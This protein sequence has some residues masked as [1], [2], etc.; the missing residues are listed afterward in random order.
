[1]YH[2]DIPEEEIAKRFGI[3]GSYMSGV[4]THDP[5]YNRGWYSIA[6]RAAIGQFAIQMPE[7][8]RDLEKI[9]EIRAKY[10]KNGVMNMAKVKEEAAPIINQYAGYKNYESILHNPNLA[11]MRGYDMLNSLEGREDVFMLLSNAANFNEV[12]DEHAGWLAQ[13]E[14]AIRN[15]PILARDISGQMQQ[16]YFNVK[17]NGL[18]DFEATFANLQRLGINI[19]DNI[20]NRGV[21]ASQ[22]VVQFID[23][24]KNIQDQIT[25]YTTNMQK[26]LEL[27]NVGSWLD[28]YLWN[29]KNKGVKTMGDAKNIARTYF[30]EVEGIKDDS[31]IEKRVNNMTL[32]EGKKAAVYGVSK[33]GETKGIISP[34]SKNWRPTK[35]TQPVVTSTNY[36]SGG[37]SGSG[38]STDKNKNNNAYGNHYSRQAARPTQIIV[39]VGNLASFDKTYIA[40]DAQERDMVM[41]LE[42]RIGMAIQNLTAQLAGQLS[43]V[44][45]NAGSYSS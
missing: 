44:G 23:T 32:E 4:G 18:I 45:D 22:F 41:A 27:D 24:T 11:A 13:M 2:L 25:E 12:A 36:S 14:V 42:E 8:Q 16:F 3:H 39:N 15:T 35:N 34:F 20:Y 9:K 5:K 29:T 37:S 17:S 1:M 26:V 40:K 21:W 30:R 28:L 31:E 19:A 10:T 6:M 38:G 33:V 7:V 43:I